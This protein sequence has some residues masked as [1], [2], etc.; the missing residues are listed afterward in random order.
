MKVRGL[1]EPFLRML[2]LLLLEVLCSG[3]AA[4]VKGLLIPIFGVV[5]KGELLLSALPT[6]P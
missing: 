1:L 6:L 5:L 3:D 2:L 4:S